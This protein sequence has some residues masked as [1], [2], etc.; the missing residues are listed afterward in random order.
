MRHSF[1][2]INDTVYSSAG[3]VSVPNDCYL[4]LQGNMNACN[5]QEVIIFFHEK[6]QVC[7]YD[8]KGRSHF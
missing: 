3:S 6:K 1:Q 5:T 4:V 8:G 2:C 7:S